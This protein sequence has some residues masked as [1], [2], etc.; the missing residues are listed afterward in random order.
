VSFYLENYVRSLDP[1]LIRRY[2]EGGYC[3]V[4]T[5]STM[6]GRA[7][8]EPEKVPRAIAY[9]AELERRGRLVY[10][11]SPFRKGADPVPFDFDW[12]FDYYPGAYE[13]PGALMKVY[14]LRGGNCARGRRS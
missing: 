7:E 11:A 4:V 14:E 10:T 12:S 5:G 1:R 9:Y 6:R 3:W 2:E 8:A 13:R